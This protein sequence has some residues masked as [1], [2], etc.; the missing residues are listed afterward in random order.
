MRGDVD[1]FLKTKAKALP[2]SLIKKNFLRLQNS[3]EG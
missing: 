3:Q 2:I 1:N